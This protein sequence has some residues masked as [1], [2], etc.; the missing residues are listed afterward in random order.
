MGVVPREI[1]RRPAQEIE[2]VKAQAIAARTYAVGNMG[3]REALGFDFFASVMDQA[4]GGVPDEDSIA[5]RAIRETR[6]EIVTYDGTPILA[7]YSSTCGGQTAAI[8]EAWPWR[9]PLPYLRSVSDRIPGTDDYYCATSNRFHWATTWTRAQLL[10]TL[11][12]TLR[13]YTRTTGV[14]PGRVQNLEVLSRSASGRATL[15]LETNGNTYTL[16][17]DSL[18]WVLRTP[19]GGLLN[20]ARIANIALHRAADGAVDSLTIAGGGWGHGIGMC[21]VGALGRARAGQRYDQI[22]RTYYPGTELE[23]RY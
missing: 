19:I 13:E 23:R 15:R 9:A 5:T 7:Y 14:Q 12:A 6:G 20:S 4:Y 21:Q 8:D 3:G 11:G 17:A 18:R 10:S 1:G 16:R 22:L 2:A